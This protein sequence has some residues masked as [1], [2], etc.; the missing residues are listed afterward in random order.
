M[1]SMDRIRIKIKKCFRIF[2]SRD[3]PVVIIT[4]MRRCVFSQM[5]QTISTRLLYDFDI[6]DAC[7]KLFTEKRFELGGRNETE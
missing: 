5:K 7:I 1:R 4:I 2:T 3:I 6:V